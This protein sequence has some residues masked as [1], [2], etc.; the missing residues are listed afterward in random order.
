MFALT[1]RVVSPEEV[2]CGDASR[3]QTGLWQCVGH[4]GVRFYP[5]ASL[6]AAVYRAEGELTTQN[7]VKAPSPY[8]SIFNKELA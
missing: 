8:P 3:P 5:G 1:R 4:E 7:E 6:L 2:E